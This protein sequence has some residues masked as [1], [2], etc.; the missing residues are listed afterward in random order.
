MRKFKLLLTGILLFSSLAMI[1]QQSVKGVVKDKATGETLPGVS[2]VVKGT[3]NGTSTDF[4]G[5]FQLNNV[6]SGDVLVFTYLGFADKEV[7][8]AN[9]FNLSVEMEESSERLEEIVVVGYGTT[10]VKDATGSVEAITEKD[11]TKGNI[12]TPENLLSGRVSGVTITQTGAPGEAGQIRIRGGSSISASNDPLIIIDGLPINNNGVSGSRGVLSSINP[13]DI[14]SFSV[15]KDASATAIYGS[16]ASNGVIIITTKKGKKGFSVD[17]DLQYSTAENSNR[18]DVFTADEFRNI[19]AQQRPASSGS[20]NVN[21][22]GNANTD[23][24][25]EIFRTAS[26]KILN[27]TTRGAIFGMPT[28]LSLGN[29]VQ[30]GV[31]IHDKYRRS[32][33]SLSLNPSFFDS[34]LKIN[35]NANYADTASDFADRGQIGAALRYDPTQPVFD[36]LSPFGGYYQHRNGVVI[37]NGTTNPVANLALN[38]NLG[39]EE[40]FYGNFNVDYKFHSLPE[41]RAVVD[42][43]YDR[44]SGN[45]RNLGSVFLPTTDPDL[46]FEGSESYNDQVRTNTNFNGYFNYAKAFDALSTDFTAGYSYQKFENRGSFTGNLR[47]PNNIGG[48][49]FVDTDVVLIGYFARAELAYNDKYRLTLNYRRDGTS[50]F[51]EDNRWGNFYGAA[52]AWQISEEEFLRD[53]NVISTLKLRGSYGLNGQQEIGVGAIF[54]NR[55]RF[56]NPNSQYSFGG[57]VINPAVPQELNPDLKW[58][59]TSTAEIGLDYGLFD[60]RITGTFSVYR[61]NSNDLL[62]NTPVAEG[63]NFTNSI[64]QNIGDLQTDGFEFAINADIIDKENMNWSVNF[65]GSFIDRT[66]KNLPLGQDIRTGGIAG[67]TGNTIQLLREGAAPFSFHVFKQ[68]YDTNGNPIEGAFA[69]L[70]GNGII[71]DDDR[72]LKENPDAD[73]NLGFQSTFNY[74]NWDF[75][76]NLRASIGNYVYNNVNSSRAQFELLQDNAVLGNIPTSVLNTGFQRT[77]D[78]IISDIYVENAS[79]LRMDNVTLGYTLQEPFKGFKSIRFWTGVQNVFVWTDYSGLD[80]EVFGGIDNTIYPRPRTFLFGANI[81]F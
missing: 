68:L 3:T 14:E 67:G 6:K 10:T 53:N 48:D 43:G 78:V 4:D 22:L 55:F 11:F 7:T 63:T 77:S 47:D 61:K 21:D 20:P 35:V 27:L 15:L 73:A 32:N 80:P 13:N 71:N 2:V 44:L 65:N 57:Q 31:L 29:T 37:A 36:P 72:Y 46:L 54:L 69:D 16:R 52:A 39:D 79:F 33:V 51:S 64:V 41:L 23:W 58:E 8:L 59:E 1:A 49:T 9:N 28:R 70:D 5:N 45:F 74:N 62:F 75:A 24:Q 76:F 18:I 42:L 17:L 26:Q 34:H 66:M 56:G 38:Q 40:R 81:K 50:R 30:E 19:V 12:V 60:D 25:D